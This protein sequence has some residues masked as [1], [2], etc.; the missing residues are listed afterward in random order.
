MSKS[1]FSE[2]TGLYEHSSGTEN[3]KFKT[4]QKISTF[5]LN[6]HKSL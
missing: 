4:P 6:T 3:T 2:F 5:Y 1:N